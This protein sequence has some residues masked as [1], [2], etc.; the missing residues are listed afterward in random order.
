[1]IVA[2]RVV[3]VGYFMPCAFLLMV[4]DNNW[5]LL[6][7]MLAEI[8]ML[9]GQFTVF[10]G[11]I[12]ALAK[13]VTASDGRGFLGSPLKASLRAV[14][15]VVFKTTTVKHHRARGEDSAPTRNAFIGVTRH[16]ML[17]ER[18]AFSAGLT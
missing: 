16:M 1:M 10:S 13:N 7:R 8:E 5:G 6:V 11:N 14:Q 17:S 15:K 2:P 9:L 12:F 4:H 18:T 3:A